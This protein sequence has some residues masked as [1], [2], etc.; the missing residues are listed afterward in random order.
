MKNSYIRIIIT[1]SL[2]FILFICTIFFIHNKTDIIKSI[3]ARSDLSY[4]Y[5]KETCL[6]VKDE[7]YAE[8]FLLNLENFFRQVS[9]TGVSLGLNFGFEFMEEDKKNSKRFPEGIERDIQYSLYYLQMN[10]LAI[11]YAN[12]KFLGIDF[13]YGFFLSGLYSYYSKAFEFSEDMIK[14]LESSDGISKIE[15]PEL[16]KRF[17]DRFVELK[18]DYLVLKHEKETFLE[19][20]KRRLKSAK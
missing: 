13:L 1:F 4:S 8:C 16:Q 2:C 17:Q 6:E 14:G 3:G 20:E 10:N 15:K 5:M 11:S 7:V 19:N 18:N 9:L 12:Q